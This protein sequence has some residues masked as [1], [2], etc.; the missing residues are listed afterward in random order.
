MTSLPW[1]AHNIEKYERRTAHLSM[2]QHGAYRLMMDHYY[3]TAAPLPA[4]AEQVHRICRAVADSEQEA[5]TSVLAEFFDLRDDGWHN[6]KADE[7]LARMAAISDKRRDAA[8]NSHSGRATA[9]AK[10]PANTD[11]KPLQTD[12]KSTHTS[13]ST[14][15]K[16]KEDALAR[17]DDFWEVCP[18]KTGKGEAERAWPKAIRLADADILVAAMR[19]YA[20][21]QDG[22]DKTFTKTPGPWLNGKHWLDEGIAPADSALSDGELEAFRAAWGGEAGKLIDALGDKGSVI[23]QSWFGDADFEPG[24]PAHIRLKKEFARQYVERKFAGPLRAAFGEV[25]LEVAA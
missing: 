25:V 24:P 14:V 20:A 16:K 6:E 17:F 5:V 18:K 19:S 12:S 15:T 9:Q 3:K 4:K 2:L 8:K 21:S 1:Y 10:S 11:A 23:F 7:E 13:H 22:K